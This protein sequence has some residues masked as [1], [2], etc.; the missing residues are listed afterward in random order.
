[1]AYAAPLVAHVAALMT[2]VAALVA[3]VASLALPCLALPRLALLCLVCSDNSGSSGSWPRDPG[4]CSSV[5]APT[6]LGL[7]LVAA[8]LAPVAG[9]VPSVAV[10]VLSMAVLVLLVAVLVLLVV[11]HST[12]FLGSCGGP[13]TGS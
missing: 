6:L 9:L 3:H 13:K 1:M 7:V 4:R 5:P 2:H 8:L 10:L 11:A 12:L